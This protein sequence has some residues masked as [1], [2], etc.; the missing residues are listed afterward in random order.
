MKYLTD[1]EFTGLFEACELPPE[2]FHHREHLRLA[3]IYL[4]RYGPD[5]SKVRL[6]RSIRTYAA[7]HGAP[8]KYHET[9]TVAWLQL[10]EHAAACL[11]PESALEDLVTAFPILLRKDALEACYSRAALGSEAARGLFLEPDLMPLKSL[12]CQAN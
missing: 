6:S 11:G 4:R 12:I 5:E 9:L 2:E 10:V 7:H 8:G 1:D 3:L